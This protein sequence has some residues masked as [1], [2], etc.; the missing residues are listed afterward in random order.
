MVESY[1]M[2]NFTR[3]SNIDNN[4]K[5]CPLLRRRIYC[6]RAPHY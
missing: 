1:L 4:L 2:H 6:F 5:F 3:T